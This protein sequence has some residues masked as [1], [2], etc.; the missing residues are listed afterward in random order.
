MTGIRQLAQ[1]LQISTGTVSRAL[2]G[3]SDVS[4]ATRERVLEAARALGYVPNQSGRSLRKGA[5]NTVGIIMTQDTMVGANNDNF[6]PGVI[7]G[8]QSTLQPHG[9]DLVLLLCPC[10]E[11]PD[12]YL[13]RMVTRRIVDAMIITA[14]RKIDPRINFLQKAGMPFVSLGRSDSGTNTVWVDLD[15]EGI[16]RQ[17]VNRLAAKGHR[18]IAVTLPQS[19]IN[20]GYLFYDGY[21][22]ALADNGLSLDPALVFRAE[23]SEQGGYEVG[24]ELISMKRL[25]SAIILTAELMS[26]GLYRRLGEAG[27]TPGKDL[28]IIAERESPVGRFLLP[29]LTCFKL[30]LH[31]L[32]TQLGRALLSQIPKYQN[33]YGN[34]QAET[35]WPMELVTGES[36]VDNLLV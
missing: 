8:L 31:A 12:T 10:D 17:A 23:S 18:H 19:D 32:G 5:T 28:A 29:R 20:L 34:V 9:L 36:D 30:D 25:P 11:D 22:T 33:D 15:F 6:F 21:R 24:D 7:D 3:K 2:N 14:T 1:Y 13:Q 16:A 4:D 26:V 35:I 27:L